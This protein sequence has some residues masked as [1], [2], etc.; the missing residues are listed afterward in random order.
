MLPNGL[1]PSMV[2][3]ITLVGLLEFISN[4]ISCGD[5]IRSCCS[6]TEPLNGHMGRLSKRNKGFYL[7]AFSLHP[8][9]PH[10]PDSHHVPSTVFTCTWVLLVR[11][12]GITGPGCLWTHAHHC[13]A[14]VKT[15]ERAV[16]Q[17]CFADTKLESSRS[18]F[19]LPLPLT[20]LS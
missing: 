3:T 15:S 2:M 17:R 11:C 19:C 1:K 13:H 9:T 12:V 8:H 20:G 16:L 4:W 5:E 7:L 6:L 14:Q 10:Q 18:G